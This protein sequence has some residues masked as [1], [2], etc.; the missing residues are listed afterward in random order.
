[1]YESKVEKIYGHLSFNDH[2][3]VK[4]L[5]LSQMDADRKEQVDAAWNAVEQNYYEK[6]NFGPAVVIASL[7]LGGIL[8]FLIGKIV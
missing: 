4:P 5:D 6:S 1:M 3:L 8:G 2:K 7:A